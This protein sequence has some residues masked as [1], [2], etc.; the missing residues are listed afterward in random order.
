MI[1]NWMMET[2]HKNSAADE[3]W[4]GFV[5]NHMLYLVCGMSFEELSRY[6]KLDRASSSKGGYAKIRIRA[7]V[8]ELKELLPRA[9]LLGSESLLTESVKNRGDGL[10]KIVVERWTAEKWVKNSTPFFADGDVTVNGRK[11]QVKLYDAEL[12]NEP[13]LRRHFG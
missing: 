10:E 8:G 6:F 9:I 3:Y 4:F 2:Y 7:K 5:L 1:M 12:T 11:V 13:T